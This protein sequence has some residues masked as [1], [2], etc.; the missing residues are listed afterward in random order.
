MLIKFFCHFYEQFKGFLQFLIWRL[1]ISVFQIVFTFKSLQNTLSKCKKF[2]EN[3]Q[4]TP[5]SKVQKMAVQQ[6]N[7]NFMRMHFL[8]WLKIIIVRDNIG[9]Y[10]LCK[11]IILYIFT[12]GV[13][14]KIEFLF[15]WHSHR[16]LSFP[17]A[18]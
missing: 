14:I 8:K 2:S 3:Y 12:Y 9:N 11:F 4:F 6:F 17:R 18:K 1:P 10:L 16:Y 7:Q 15:Q 5:A 13:D